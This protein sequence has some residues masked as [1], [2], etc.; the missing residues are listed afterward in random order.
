MKKRRISDI[1]MRDNNDPW[2]WAFNPTIPMMESTEHYF[3]SVPRFNT[4]NPY[5][6]CPW[7][8]LKLN[9]SENYKY[10]PWCGKMLRKDL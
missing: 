9:T 4:L 1:M 3:N 8:G 7:C 5:R 6:Y 2:M 10:C